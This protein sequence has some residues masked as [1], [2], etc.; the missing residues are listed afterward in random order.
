[1]KHCLM[2][3]VQKLYVLK[4]HRAAY[5]NTSFGLLIICVYRISVF[6]VIN[7]LLINNIMLQ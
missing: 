5:L 7:V 2:D 1:M 4:L 3:E 6:V